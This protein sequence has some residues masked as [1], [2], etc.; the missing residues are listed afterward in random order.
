MKYKTFS[1]WNEIGFHVVKGEKSHKRNKKGEC[2]FSE[3][4]V[5]QAECLIGVLDYD[6]P[7]MDLFP[8]NP[9]D[10]GHG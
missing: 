3:K 4:Q 1:Q 9:M 5:R 2:L 6:D 7:C 8:G 10:Y